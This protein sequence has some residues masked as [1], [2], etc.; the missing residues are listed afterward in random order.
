MRFYEIAVRTTALF[1]LVVIGGCVTTEV[2]TYS[3]T[4]ENVDRL[5]AGGH[6]HVAVERFGAEGSVQRLK[7]RADRFVSPYQDS[8][9]VYIEE[10]L[11][12]ELRRAERLDPSAAVILGGVLLKNHL[13]VGVKTG[14]QE[15]AVRF[16]VRRNGQVA[17][18]RVHAW[19]DEWP[20]YSLAALAIPLAR[21]R[22]PMSVNRLLGKLFADPEFIAAIRQ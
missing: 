17:Y 19:R 7:A 3:E 16:V 9:S 1:A 11:K 20:S 15:I 22:Y 14:R 21:S 8:F 4:V 18:D 10:A 6:G 13:R 5:R 12:A 2:P